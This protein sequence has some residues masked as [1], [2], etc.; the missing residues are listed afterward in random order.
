MKHDINLFSAIHQRK[1]VKKSRPTVFLLVLGLCAGISLGAM[2]GAIGMNVA[3]EKE[4]RTSK[5][6]LLSEETVAFLQEY[7]INETALRNAQTGAVAVDIIESA[8]NAEQ[9]FTV[10]VYKKIEQL[11]PA[12]VMIQS[13]S[14]ADKNVTI[15]C[16]TTDS[17]PPADYAKA[18]SESATFGK[19][20]Y[21][22]FAGA[23]EQVVFAI[24][25][26]L[27]EGK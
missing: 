4:I 18:L 2:A 14:Y 7:T 16:T 21:K 22:G 19:V 25:C 13:L 24:V 27:M 6:L 23:G 5:A 8:A 17:T 10:P 20:T 1:A 11:R 15:N 12:N 3:V 26:E 9:A